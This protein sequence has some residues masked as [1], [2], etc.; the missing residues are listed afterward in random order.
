MARAVDFV[1]DQIRRRRSPATTKGESSP[2]VDVWWKKAVRKLWRAFWA[3][4][5]MVAGVGAVGG[6]VLGH[7]HDRL[8]QAPDNFWPRLVW[9]PP[10][11]IVAVLLMFLV[12]IGL[13]GTDILESMREWAGACEAP[14][15]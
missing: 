6:V 10:L 14:G 12:Y 15:F 3:L 4:L 2:V 5:A 8:A 13:R 1:A 11:F 9:A 7:F